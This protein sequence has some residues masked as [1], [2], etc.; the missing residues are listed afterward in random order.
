MIRSVT[1]IIFLIMAGLP[2]LTFSQI[3]FAKPLTLD[4]PDVPYEMARGDF[5]NDGKPDIVTSN[6]TTALN[7]QVTILLSNSSG[8]FTG[9]DFRH[10]SATTQVTDIAT[11]DFNKDGD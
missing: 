10:F 6:F 9:S 3:A 5:N 11:G 2:R 8:S 7:Q 1:V 4:A